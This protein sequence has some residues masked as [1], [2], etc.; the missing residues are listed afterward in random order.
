MRFIELSSTLGICAEIASRRPEIAPRQVK[1][2]RRG[3]V[4]PPPPNRT[5]VVY[6]EV[7][8]NTYV[9]KRT[10]GERMGG[11]GVRFATTSKQKTL[12]IQLKLTEGAKLVHLMTARGQKS[13]LDHFDHLERIRSDTH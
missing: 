6:D 2:L 3:V 10:A 4:I 11:A 7:R 12:Y 13:T 1:M 8:L 9:I 5:E